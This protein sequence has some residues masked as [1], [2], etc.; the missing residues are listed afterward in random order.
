[1]RG[2]RPWNSA[3]T[4]LI[5]HLNEVPRKAMTAE[6]WFIPFIWV[7]NEKNRGQIIINIHF[8]IMLNRQ[9][10]ILFDALKYISLSLKLDAPI[11]ATQPANSTFI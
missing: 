10:P 3:L 7:Y 9:N 11:R 6:I 8:S 1:M 5:P 4:M 2:F